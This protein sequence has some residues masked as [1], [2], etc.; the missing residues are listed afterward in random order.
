MK[1]YDIV[2]RRKVWFTISLVLMVVALVATFFPGVKLDI[3]FSGGTIITYSFTGQLDKNAFTSTVESALAG[4]QVSLQEQQDM[5]TGNTQYVVTLSERSGITPD[6]QIAVNEALAQ[7]FPDNQV[8]VV[9]LSNVDPTIGRDFFVKSIAAVALA[10]VVMI[11]YIAF[12]FRKM[13]GW[14][15]GVISVLALLHDVIIAYAA[16]VV[17]GFPLNDSFIAV[18]L[19]ILGY[20][21]NNTIIIYDRVR[22]NRRLL[23][24]RTS[25]AELVNISVTQSLGRSINTTVSTV[26][27]VAC[28]C[29]L[30]VLYHVSSILTF[31][32]PLLVGMF[33][34]FFSSVFIAGPLWAFWQER[35][36][37]QRHAA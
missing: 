18:V 34:G 19:T 9:N 30:S 13:N 37:A 6:E 21:I 5:N 28:V 24:Q 36:A 33:A 17:C 31:S 20:S 8:E 14:S 2:G 22:E 26:I 15:A 29:V 12:R 11:L 3:Q 7:A 16:F 27:A 1:I 23:P 25:Y 10:A 4:R 32:L 35:R